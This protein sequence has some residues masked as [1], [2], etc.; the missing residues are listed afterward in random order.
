MGRYRDDVAVEPVPGTLDEHWWRSV[1]DL[2]R[3]PWDGLPAGGAVALRDEWLRLDGIDMPI[4]ERIE[5]LS[6]FAQALGLPAW[7]VRA[8]VLVCQASAR[9]LAADPQ[10]DL[11]R[12]LLVMNAAAG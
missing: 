1:S 5:I 8:R 12:R 10:P 6:R 9:R 7:A 3:F 4:P 11:A 2:G